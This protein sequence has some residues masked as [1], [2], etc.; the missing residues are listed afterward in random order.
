[1]WEIEM[2]C[3]MNA[4]SLDINCCTNQNKFDVLHRYS[5]LREL[6]SFCLWLLFLLALSGLNSQVAAQDDKTV[7]VKIFGN[8]SQQTLF[9]DLMN[10]TKEKLQDYNVSLDVG[11]D[12]SD[13][14][15]DFNQNLPK[16]CIRH[17][18]RMLQAGSL[19]SPDKKQKA[20]HISHA[21]P[22][23]PEFSAR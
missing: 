15:K 21:R 19:R 4:K 5:P 23:K 12:Q 22:L 14:K 13:L 20:A 9:Y 17:S 16:N 1:M 7:H 11:Q 10:K 18:G 6:A 3:F 2:D 8:Q